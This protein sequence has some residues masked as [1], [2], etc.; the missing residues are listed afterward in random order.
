MIDNLE[1]IKP[2]LSFSTGDDFY[3]LQILRRKKENPDDIG[4]IQE[5][6]Q[7]GFRDVIYYNWDNYRRLHYKN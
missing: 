7:K 5:L 3:Y 6:E 1:L 2:L 4:K